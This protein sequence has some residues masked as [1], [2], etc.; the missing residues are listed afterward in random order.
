M[1]LQ[2][3][4][5]EENK[6]LF[7]EFEEVGNIFPSDGVFYVDE[8]P[9]RLETI[10]PAV[11]ESKDQI[12]IEIM[13][14]AYLIQRNT[15]YCVFFSYH[16]HVESFD[17][18]ISKSKEQWQENVLETEF[19]TV[20]KDYLK[21]NDPLAFFKAKRDVLLSI[22]QEKEIPYELCDVERYE[23]EEYSF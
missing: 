15:S 13:H 16:G 7:F 11:I 10:Q 14:L 4:T 3:K 5:L 6:T 19:Y 17:V 22:V 18:R 2:A 8:T 9:C 12:I 20:F 21:N 23:V 1:R